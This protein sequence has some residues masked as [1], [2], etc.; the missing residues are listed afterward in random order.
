MQVPVEMV[1]FQ[2]LVFGRFLG[3][4]SGALGPCLHWCSWEGCSASSCECSLLRHRP[5]LPVHMQR[6]P[7]TLPGIEK[8]QWL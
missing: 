1:D 3:E 8:R 2:E 4:G 6:A 7:C 5:L